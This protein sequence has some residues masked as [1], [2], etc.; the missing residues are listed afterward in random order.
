MLRWFGSSSYPRYRKQVVVRVNKAL[1]LYFILQQSITGFVFLFV[2]EHMEGG[3]LDGDVLS[4]RGGV[5]W[6]CC[7]CCGC[8]I[9]VIARSVVII[10]RLVGL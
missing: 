8:G 4:R 7:C 6:V 10:G 9:V 2:A 5:S 3:T 1:K